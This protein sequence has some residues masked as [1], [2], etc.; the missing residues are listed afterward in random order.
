MRVIIVG[1]G[2][3]GTSLA[4]AMMAHKHKVAIIERSSERC[5]K[6]VKHLNTVTIHGDGTN[7]QTLS[8][9]EVDKADVLIA[10]T[11]RD[12]DNLISCQL[13]SQKFKVPRTLARIRYARNKEV[14]EKLGGVTT[15]LSTT[16]IVSSLIEE[17]VSLKDV[18]TLLSFRE[19][20][21]AIVELE[22]DENSP[23]RDKKIIDIDLPEDCIIISVFR[24]KERIFPHGDTVL[25]VKDRILAITTDEKKTVLRNLLVG[26]APS[27]P[28]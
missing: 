3:I 16:D 12:Q 14:F 19:G 8:D 21:S 9:A 20:R 27:I 17:E 18:T 24:E 28:R 4:K 22:I 1:G 5:N 25:K 13:A 6:I 26:I 15:V 10:L 23:V 7:L 11:N 2:E